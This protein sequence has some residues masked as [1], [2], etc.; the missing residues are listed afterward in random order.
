MTKFVF[1]MPRYHTN[2][3]P[4]VRILRAGGHDV[5]IHVTAVGPTENHNDL[6]PKMLMPSLLSR[7]LMTFFARGDRRELWVSPAFTDYFRI[8]RRENA[9]VVVVRGVTRWFCRLAAICAMLQGKKLVIYDQEDIAPKAWGTW[10]RRSGFRLLGVH[11]MTTRL[12]TGDPTKW[13]AA[14]PLP[15]GNSFPQE[16]VGARRPT[17]WPPRLLMV[18]KYRERKEHRTLIRAAARIAADHSFT[19]TF[20]GE[21][22]SI[23]DQDFCADLMKLAVDLGIGD[24]VKFINNVPHSEMKQVYDEHD[25][26]VLPSRFEPAAVSP[27]EAAW[28]GC[29]VLISSDSGTRG[30]VPTDSDFDFATGD[31]DIL[32]QKLSA[33]LS[34]KEHL[35]RLRELCFSHISRVAD[36]RKVLASFEFM[37]FPIKDRRSRT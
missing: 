6:S 33:M 4:W 22:A 15:F 18:A 9:D 34:T 20:C 1:C 36:D 37:T 16:I 23:A 35:D 13:G 3:V 11:H 25:L 7:V 12:A 27:I 32:S 17:H 5:S 10:M 14:F 31:V 28:C 30:Y 19:L 8:L 21:V 26:F 2:M 29:A 24:R